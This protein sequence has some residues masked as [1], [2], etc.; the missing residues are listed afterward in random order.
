MKKLGKLKL[1]E[2]SYTIGDLETLPGAEEIS[3]TTY[4]SDL[5]NGIRF[6]YYDSNLRAIVKGIEDMECS[7]KNLIELNLLLGQM[8]IKVYVKDGDYRIETE[9]N[10]DSILIS[11]PHGYL[12]F[13]LWDKE[14]LVPIDRKLV[15]DSMTR[16][17]AIRLLSKRLTSTKEKLEN[18]L[19]EYLTHKTINFKK[20]L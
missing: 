14:L 9:Y 1:N 7:I 10:S 6:N 15:T 5:T 11:V 13:E 16:N 20:E 8:P 19:N 4:L 18:L 3:L 2:D 12:A 17:A